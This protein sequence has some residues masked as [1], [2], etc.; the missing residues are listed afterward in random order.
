MRIK[1][2]LSKPISLLPSS[3]HHH[4]SLR[5][6]VSLSFVLIYPMHNL[7]TW[8]LFP[9]QQLLKTMKKYDVLLNKL[10][11]KNKGRWCRSPSKNVH[12]LGV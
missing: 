3:Q 1:T 9:D 12:A 7:F 5:L 11:Y 2:E 6:D 4:P 10:F 8:V